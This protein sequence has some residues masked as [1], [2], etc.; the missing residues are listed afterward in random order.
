MVPLAE[1]NASRAVCRTRHLTAFAAGLFVP[2]N[3][4]SFTIPVSTSDMHPRRPRNSAE[5][6][7]FFFPLAQERSGAPSLVVLL[8]CVLGLLSYA[9]AAAILHKLDQ[10]DLRRAAVVPLC[11]CDGLFKYEIQVKTGWSRG[12][13]GSLQRFGEGLIKLPEPFKSSSYR[14][15][16]FP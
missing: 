6:T 5:R 1:T 8:V 10:L 15:V 14:K 11:G 12:A 7:V 2:A 9:V 16:S 3:A 13:G 4:I